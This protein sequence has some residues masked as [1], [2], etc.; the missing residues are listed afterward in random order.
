MNWTPT[1]LHSHYSLLDG[2]SKPNQIAKRCTELGY[3]SCSLTDHGG[4]SGA[5]SFIK[6]MKDVCA[7]GEQKNNHENGSGKCRSDNGCMEFRKKPIKPILGSEFYLCKL[8]PQIKDSINDERS[9]LCVLAKNLAGWK[10][11]IQLTSTAN[12]KDHFYKKP[13]LRLEEFADLSN[14]NLVAFSGHIGSDLGNCLFFNHREAYDNSNSVEIARSYL[15]EDWEEKASYVIG[16]YKEVFGKENFFV[17][18]QRVDQKNLPVTQ[19]IADCLVSV[20]KKTGTRRI[21][22]A[23]SHYASQEDAVDQRVLLGSLLQSTFKEIEEK[24]LNSQEVALGAFFNSN[25]YHIPSIEELAALHDEEEINNTQIIDEMCEVYDVF[26]KPMFPKF[27]CPNNLDPDTYLKHLCDNGWNNKFNPRIPENRKQEYYDRINMELGVFKEAGLAPYFLIVQDYCKFARDK[28]W[29]MSAGRGSAAGSLVAALIGITSE[30][31]DPVENK[32]LFERFYNAGR[33][34]PGRISLPDI[35][36]DFPIH[37]RAE[38]Y[39][40]VQDKYGNDKVCQMVT[41]GRMQGRSALKDVLRFWDACSFEEMSLITAH[42]PDEAEI[43]D[44]LQVMREETGEASI[45]RWALENNSDK[46]KD[47]CFIDKDGNIDGAYAKYFKQAIRMEGTKRSQGKHAAGVIISSENLSELC[48]MVYDKNSDGAVAGLEM[49][50]LEALGLV[51][52]DFLGVSLLDKIMNTVQI[53]K[54]GD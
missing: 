31:A 4:L 19:I 33:N 42:I 25:N 41:F 26:N 44:E 50:D 23:D 20:A 14:N 16:F 54:Y 37:K 46:L 38:V 51:K 18:I 10:S 15:S 53:L 24:R 35:D 45:I 17:E 39:K 30:V 5:I 34:A 47:Y 11:L 52:F 27:D 2:L 29:L 21:A 6:A 40:Y 12:R 28:G 9:H 7:C 32:L 1:H 49:N 43:S 22:T 3:K 36:C 8:D 13:R 48:P